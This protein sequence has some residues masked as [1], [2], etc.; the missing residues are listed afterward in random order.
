MRAYIDMRR[1]PGYKCARPG[2]FTASARGRPLPGFIHAP[3]AASLSAPSGARKCAAA[4]PRF[5]CVDSVAR[6]V[7]RGRAFRFPATAPRPPGSA[8]SRRP[9][10]FRLNRFRRAPGAAWA[11]ISASATALRPPVSSQSRHPAGLRLNRFRCAP[12]A[13]RVISASATAPRPHVSAQSR[14]RPSFC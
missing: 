13:A 5:S 8:Q 12:S 9:A 1:P 14:T 11:S 7:R 10:G 3:P 2:R 6:S 4:L